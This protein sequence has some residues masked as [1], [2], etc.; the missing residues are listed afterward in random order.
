[1]V[2]IISGT[3]AQPPRLEVR[4]A[5]R[6]GA[7]TDA[8]AFMPVSSCTLTDWNLPNL[9]SAGGLTASRQLYSLDVAQRGEYKDLAIEANLSNGVSLQT[10]AS[11]SICFTPMGRALVSQDGARSWT[12]LTSV[13]IANVYRDGGASGPI[14]LQ[15]VVALLPNG[16]ARL[17]VAGPR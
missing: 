15:R 3:A 17:D 13:P 9:V 4:E 7:A 11:L 14:G 5:V 16:S 1:M 8:A 12:T 2:R 6:G 10:V